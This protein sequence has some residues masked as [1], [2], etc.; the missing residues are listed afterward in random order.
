MGKKQKWIKI[1]KKTSMLLASITAFV[2]IALSVALIAGG[3]YALFADTVTLQTTLQAGDLEAKLYRTGYSKVYM[4]ESGETHRE[5]VTGLNEDFTNE[6]Q[7]NVFGIESGEYIVPTCW[8]Q[9]NLVLRNTDGETDTKAVAFKYWVEISYTANSNDTFNDLARQLKV[10]VE[11]KGENAPTYDDTLFSI[12]SG[13]VGVIGGESNPFGVLKAGEEQ[14]FSV[15]IEFLDINTDEEENNK[16]QNETV[17][18]N[19]TV[20]AVQVTADDAVNP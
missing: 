6:T 15:K 18:F 9:T 3:T 19:L 16:A 12:S 8:Y 2:L 10:T 14:E 1:R 13:K 5:N 11:V 7:K 17:S 4:G 20:H